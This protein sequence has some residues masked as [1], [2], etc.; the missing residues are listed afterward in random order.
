MSASAIWPLQICQK[1]TD[2][3]QTDSLMHIVCTVSIQELLA[4]L[5]VF[6][7]LSG[8]IVAIDVFSECLGQLFIKPMLFARKTV[9]F[10]EQSS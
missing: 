2:F 1:A 9:D 6:M 3:W 7:Y 5:S 8:R 4:V 10:W